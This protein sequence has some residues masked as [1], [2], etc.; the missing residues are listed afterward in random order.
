[1]ESAFSQPVNAVNPSSEP[2][3]VGAN[4]CKRNANLV[5]IGGGDGFGTL[6]QLTPRPELS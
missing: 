1:M 3:R 6:G 4:D 5:N 2:W